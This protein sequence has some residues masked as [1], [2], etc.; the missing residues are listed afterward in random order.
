MMIGHMKHS[1]IKHQMNMQHKRFYQ[2][3]PSENKKSETFVAPLHYS[4][5]FNL[6]LAGC[7]SAEPVSVSIEQSKIQNYK[8]YLQPVEKDS[9]VPPLKQS[10]HPFLV[11]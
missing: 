7:S 11:Y 6:S 2:A 4:R 5:R 8:L 1:T 3:C 10:H 9:H